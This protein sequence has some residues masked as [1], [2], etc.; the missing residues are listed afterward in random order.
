MLVYI[1]APYSTGGTTMEQN[2]ANARRVAVR[3]WQ[4]GYHVICPHLNTAHFEQ[5]CTCTWEDYI[6]GD[7]DMISRVDAVIALPDWESSKGAKVEVEYAKA[8][9][10]PVYFYPKLPKIPKA[11]VTSPVQ[12]EAFRNLT[13][14]MYRVHVRKNSDYSPANIIGTG[15][16]GVMVRIWDK[17]IRLMNLLGFNIEVQHKDGKYI[18]TISDEPVNPPAEAANESLE[19]SFMDLA[20]YGAIGLLLRRDQWG[21]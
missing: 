6:A 7:L 17:T 21:H 20:V 9:D 15:K 19:D 12:C 2:L 5:D 18:L 10:I 11:E 4:D 13:S 14:S 8:H 3:L 1:S 16:K